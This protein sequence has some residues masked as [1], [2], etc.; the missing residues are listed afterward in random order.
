MLRL[1]KKAGYQVESFRIETPEDLQQSIHDKA[2]DLIICDNYMPE[3]SAD[4]AMEILH[5]TGKDIPFIV[6]SGTIQEEQAAE[7][8]KK[9]AADYLF[10]NNLT[11]LIP[12]VKRELKEAQNRREKKQK[13]EELRLSEDLFSKVFRSSP[14]AITITR[15]SDGKFIELNNTA[16]EWL[17][18]TRKE[19][20]GS[21]SVELG[22]YVNPDD[23]KML[24]EELKAKGRVRNSETSFYNKKKKIIIT[25]QS[26]EILELKGEKCILSVYEDIT[27]RRKAEVIF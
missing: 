8:M 21:T 24:I 13:D 10:K 17:G 18:Y 4:K 20:I 23:R 25:L 1:I 7:L 19:L 27:E 15:M 14:V 3:L 9:G 2:W 5:E 22:L 6:V 26:L 12:S 11:R 16:V